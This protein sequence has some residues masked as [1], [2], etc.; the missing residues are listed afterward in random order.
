MITLIGSEGDYD[1]YDSSFIRQVNSVKRES[2]PQ[3]IIHLTVESIENREDR[4]K[5]LYKLNEMEWD[6]LVNSI[7]E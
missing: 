5:V 4:E 2:Y 7:I 3:S 1:I 6:Y